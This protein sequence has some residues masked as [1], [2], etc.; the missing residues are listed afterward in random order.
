MTHLG[1]LVP[2]GRICDRNKKFHTLSLL[3]S[4]RFRQKISFPK[5]KILLL[6]PPLVFRA[7][8][9]CVGWDERVRPNEQ[10]AGTPL[11]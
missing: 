3:P 2:L 1:K 11:K 7:L 8:R 5:Q 10:V 6:G 9:T 4:N